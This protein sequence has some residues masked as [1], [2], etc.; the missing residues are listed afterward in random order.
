MLYNYL[1]KIVDDDAQDKIV[2]TPRMA[3]KTTMVIEEIKKDGID[4]VLVFIPSA[5][6]IPHF[7]MKLRSSGF[8]LDK[9]ENRKNYVYTYRGIKKFID[10]RTIEFFNHQG[11]REYY[12]LAIFEECQLL[13]VDIISNIDFTRIANTI[14]TATLSRIDVFDILSPD[15]CI[16]RNS[17]LV[18]LLFR[19]NLPDF[20]SVTSFNIASENPHYYEFVSKN[21][22]NVSPSLKN[23]Y[24]GELYYLLPKPGEFINGESLR[25]KLYLYERD[26]RERGLI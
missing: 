2:L 8:H 19:G 1:R 5:R 13:I 15:L 3:G 7:D 26:L 12:N 9:I 18:H 21:Y 6:M 20:D 22:D 23:W 16:E 24:T 17:P 10:F 14:F 11:Y 4:S 25:W